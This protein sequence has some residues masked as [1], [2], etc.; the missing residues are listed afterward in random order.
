VA[1]EFSIQIVHKSLLHL[2]YGEALK[3]DLLTNGCHLYC[4]L[5]FWARFWRWVWPM[6]FSALSLMSCVNQKWFLKVILLWYLQAF[7]QHLDI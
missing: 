5:T 1:L 6:A 3:L 7:L 2:S 4:C